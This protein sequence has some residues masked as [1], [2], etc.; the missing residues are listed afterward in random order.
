MPDRDSIVTVY[1]QGHGPGK[2]EPTH[3]QRHASTGMLESFQRWGGLP[4]IMSSGEVPD[5]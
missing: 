1:V 2:L 3:N 5:F 4:F